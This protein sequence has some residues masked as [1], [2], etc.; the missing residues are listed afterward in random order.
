MSLLEQH[1]AGDSPEIRSSVV[2]EVALLKLLIWTKEIFLLFGEVAEAAMA[3]AVRA[4]ALT[5]A[6]S[7][8]I[9]LQSQFSVFE[10]ATRIEIVTKRR[11]KKKKEER[12]RC[13]SN[14]MVYVSYDR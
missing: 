1:E 2:G 4:R 11:R 3:N 7:I 5:W 13:W 6:I 10:S 14:K 9:L 8:D 12:L